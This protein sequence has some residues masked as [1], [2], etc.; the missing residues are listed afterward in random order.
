MRTSAELGDGPLLVPIN[1]TSV[2]VPPRI[3]TV[4][5]YND[6]DDRPLVTVTHEMEIVNGE[7]ETRRIEFEAPPGAPQ[8]TDN[9]LSRNRRAWY[10][11]RALEMVGFVPD[12]EDETITRP[13]RERVRTELAARPRRRVTNDRL[14]EVADAYR[15][16]GAQQVKKE[17]YVSRSQAFRL[18]GQARD[19]GL[20]GKDEGAS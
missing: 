19:A 2:R 13:D 20:L 17:L 18:V 1:G 8:L 14:R 10:Q 16:G 12:E 9:D 3:T 7:P 15:R 5:E 6:D 11:A 4:F